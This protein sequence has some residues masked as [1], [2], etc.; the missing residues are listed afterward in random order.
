MLIYLAWAD[1]EICIGLLELEMKQIVTNQETGKTEEQTTGYWYYRDGKVTIL[2]LLLVQKH[3]LEKTVL[4]GDQ[5]Y[6]SELNYDNIVNALISF[7]DNFSILSFN[8]S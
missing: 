5:F 2:D 7:K 1:D 6:S 3:I 8:S 4:V